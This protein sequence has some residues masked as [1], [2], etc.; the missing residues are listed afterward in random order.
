MSRPLLLIV[1]A[2][3]FG[4][5]LWFSGNSAAADLR[6]LWNLNERDVGAM[7]VAVQLG[8]IVGTLAFALTGFADGFRASRVFAVCAWLGALANAGFALLATGLEQALCLRFL[9]GLTLAGVYPLGMKLVVSWSP[10]S[11]GFALGWLVG[12]LTFGTATPHLVR[13][14][15]QSWPWQT[16]VLTSSGLSLLAGVVILL[17]GDGP[18]LPARAAVRAGSVVRVF[19]VPAFRASA[20]GYFGHM[21][22]LYAFWAV[23]PLLVGTALAGGGSRAATSLWSFAVIA[24]GGVGCVLGGWLSR[25]RGS[26]FVAAFSL[27]VSC[28][29]CVMYPLVQSLPAS[30]LLGLLLVWGFA[31][32]TD[33]PQFSALSARACPPDSVGGALAIQNSAG[34]LITVVAIAVVTGCWDSLG[35]RVSWILAPGP[36]LGLAGMMRLIRAREDA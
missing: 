2:E 36:L 18:H 19:R 9:T 6:P 3:L 28:A 10:K 4:T 5:S 21:W 7:A 20:F 8:F 12:A 35:P 34:F 31:V 30:A 11:S 16:V 14:L 13:G 25:R 24:A 1:L 33:S 27:V 17:L 15:G 29:V 22:E 23:V 32:V 26:A